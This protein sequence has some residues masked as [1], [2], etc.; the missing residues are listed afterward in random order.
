MHCSQSNAEAGCLWVHG[1]WWGGRGWRERGRG[2]KSRNTGKEESQG[3]SGRCQ[4]K[5]NLC[6]IFMTFS[7]PFSCSNQIIHPHH[8]TVSLRFWNNWDVLQTHPCTS[9]ERVISSLNTSRE[10]YF[11]LTLMMAKS[12]AGDEGKR[13]KHIDK[14]LGGKEGGKLLTKTPLG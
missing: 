5:K 10:R 9:S 2:N 13:A 3:G 1:D 4:K 12:L 8:A 14:V 11:T 6:I 7:L